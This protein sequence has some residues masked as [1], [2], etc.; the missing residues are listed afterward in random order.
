M[1]ETNGKHKA[2]LKLNNH[3]MRLKQA[4][5]SILEWFPSTSYG[6]DPPITITPLDL[7]R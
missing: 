7:H 4:T 1:K 3:T 6:I 5:A 2:P